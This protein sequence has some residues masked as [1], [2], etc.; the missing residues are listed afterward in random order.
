MPLLM[1]ARARRGHPLP[2]LVLIVDAGDVL[3]L[4]GE[5]ELGEKWAAACARA[6]RVGPRFQHHAAGVAVGAVVL[7]IWF[8]SRSTL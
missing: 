5:A 6:C 2:P 1:V 3:F 4:G 7:L 8:L